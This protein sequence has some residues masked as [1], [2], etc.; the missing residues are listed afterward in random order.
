[1]RHIWG[2]RWTP[3]IRRLRQI[4]K[5]DDDV[6]LE[7]ENTI[8]ELT[9]VDSH[10]STLAIS[11]MMQSKFSSLPASSP[12]LTSPVRCEK[13]DGEIGSRREEDQEGND[14][15]SKSTHKVE[16]SNEDSEENEDEDASG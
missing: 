1:M 16:A 5:I 9:Q 13:V 15:P 6:E 11:Q 2:Y 8:T 3:R 12:D 14:D 7:V 4:E 10:I